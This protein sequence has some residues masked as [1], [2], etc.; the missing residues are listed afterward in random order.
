MN[1]LPSGQ[2]HTAH[3]PA[4]SAADHRPIVFLLDAASPLEKKLL[5]D[6]ITSHRPEDVARGAWE[7]IPIPSSRRG[8]R[9]LDPGLEA[10]LAIGDDP[11]LTPL[12][13][14]WDPP[15]VDGEREIRLSDL[16]TFGDP[17]DPGR[18]RQ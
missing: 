12:R 8:N 10:R 15:N 18:L 5:E 17:R 7:T 6:W 16:W 14:A 13:V 3:E 1:A 11:M 9:R 4:W 2:P